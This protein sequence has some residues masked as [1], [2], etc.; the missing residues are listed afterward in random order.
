M[1]SLHN[2][3]G[4][5]G[6]IVGW[7]VGFLNGLL[8]MRFGPAHPYLLMCVTLA[9][10]LLVPF[11]GDALGLFLHRQARIVKSEDAI[12]SLDD[13][14]IRQQAQTLSWSNIAP[15]VLAVAVVDETRWS[16]YI[17]AVPGEDFDA[18][19]TEVVLHGTTIPHDMA[20]CLW[21]D[22]E[23]LIYQEK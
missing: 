6:G 2:M 19:A 11:L 14:D 21:P 4:F 7:V 12:E 15:Q 9:C 3:S 1:S 16:A 20:V 17:D 22:F 23:S 10:M 13:R 5:E 8:V 18:E